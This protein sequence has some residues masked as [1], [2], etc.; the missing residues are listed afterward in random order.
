MYLNLIKFYVLIFTS[1]ALP[2]YAQVLSPN[3]YSGLGLT[4]TADTIKSGRAVIA[5]DPAIPGA[6][7]NTGFNYQ[8]GFGLNENIELVG[9]LATN[10]LKCNMFVSNACPRDTIRDLSASFKWQLTNNWLRENNV[11]VAIGATDLGG[12]AAWFKSYYAVATKKF[13]P[14][15]FTIGDG[16]SKG[17]ASVLD[18]VF[19][20]VAISPTDWSKFSIQRQ[21]G[22]TLA[23]A[24]LEAPI[25]NGSLL[26]WVTLNSQLQKTATTEKKWVGVGVSFPLAKVPTRQ[27]SFKEESLDGKKLNTA[28]IN[29]EELSQKLK[30]NGFFNTRVGR[31]PSG[32][33]IYKLDATGYSWNILD[34]SGVALALIVASNSET[35][36]DK[37]FE[38]TLGLRG[39]DQIRISGE[40]KCTQRWLKT[41]EPCS[42]MAVESMLQRTTN[43]KYANLDFVEWSEENGWSF[44][45]EITL[46]PRVVSTFGTEY[47]TFD[48]DI[49]LDVNTVLPLWQGATLD[50]NKARSLGVNTKNFESGGL[51][52]YSKILPATTRSMLHQVFALPNF[53]SQFRISSGTANTYWK[54]NQLE[55]SSQ[56][57][58]GRHRIGFI[59]GN[60]KNENLINNNQR[61]YQL[62]K[63]RYAS[64]YDFNNATEV[65]SG[66][67]WAG[68]KGFSVNHKFW[69]GDTA[70]SVYFRRTRPTDASQLYSFAGLEISLPLTPRQNKGFEN[71]IIKGPSQWSYA[72]ETRVLA[73]E[74]T[75]I[76]GLG[77]VPRVGES[78]MQ[79]FN[80][81]RNST[82][83]YEVNMFRIREAALNLAN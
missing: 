59:S 61:N 43:H 76:G 16:S 1:F 79:K 14:Y 4:P 31:S 71:L 30:D 18:G 65:T 23:S 13:G 11:N 3:G 51:F 39:I 9:R 48:A 73:P 58:D 20:A 35:N 53:N 83:Y 67:F 69:H 50:T 56:T 78:L 28:K 40:I 12:A 21:S 72:L 6:I 60:F 25:L 27:E 19:G 63:Y 80:H 33:L 17:R 2:L 57:D 68:D 49:G 54:G 8:L 77:V 74:N 10:N 62:L 34:A 45:P 15:E 37:Y 52:Y 7:V 75:I 66:K 70:I 22:N 42:S 41:G 36:P 81:D 82:K 38:I 5:Y 64:G 32:N 29:P 55:S 44:R 26:G 24:Y 46:V 47:G